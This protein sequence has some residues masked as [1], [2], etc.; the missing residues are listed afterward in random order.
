MI[1]KLYGLR[2]NIYPLYVDPQG[3]GHAGVS[4]RRV[5]VFLAHKKLV[6]MVVDAQ[7]MY[8]KVTRT[9]EAHVHTRPRDYAVARPEEVLQEAEHVAF[10][11]Q[12]KV[13]AAGLQLYLSSMLPLNLV[14]DPC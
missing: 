5:Y 12:K 14:P 3:T 8:K 10:R 2:Y 1:E 4:R 13:T 9:I 6:E 11:R 7:K